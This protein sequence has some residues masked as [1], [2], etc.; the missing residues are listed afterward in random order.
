MIL[1]KVCCGFFQELVL[2]AKLPRLTLKFTKPRTLTDGQRRLVAGMLT[3]IGVDP[4]AKGRL[5][6]TEFFGDLGGRARSLDHHLHG[7]FFEL[8]RELPAVL[9]QLS[10]FPDYPILVGQLSGRFGAPQYNLTSLGQSLVDGPMKALGSWTIE[11]G[12]ELLEAQESA[13]R[14]P[15][16]RV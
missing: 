11:H 8:G 3:T 2:H 9:W 4:I 12:D 14:T 13:A 10:P 15:S 1:G 7:L 6:D 16:T 5:M